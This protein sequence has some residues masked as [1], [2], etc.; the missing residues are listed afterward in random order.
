MLSESHFSI[1]CNVCSKETGRPF[2]LFGSKTLELRSTTESRRLPASDSRLL[3]SRSSRAF[4]PCSFFNSLSARAFSPYKLGIHVV[5]KYIPGKL[6]SENHYNLLRTSSSVFSLVFS[7][8]AFLSLESVSF[9]FVFVFSR[10][11]LKFS[12]SLAKYEDDKYDISFSSDWMCER[13]S[14][15][16]KS[17]SSDRSCKNWAGQT[18]QIPINTTESK[19][20]YS[21]YARRILYSSI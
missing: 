20:T 7:W 11:F 3:I 14:A 17:C 19:V 16:S 2:A 5:T 21:W 8:M 15:F 13:S 6:L 1:T 18:K 9:N 4:W 12:F 10:S